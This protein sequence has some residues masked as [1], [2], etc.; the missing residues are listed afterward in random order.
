MWWDLLW[1]FHYTFTSESDGEKNWKSVNILATLWASV[2]CPV[3]YSR[4]IRSLLYT[5]AADCYKL[6]FV[7]FRS[8]G[9]ASPDSR[10]FLIS[11][12]LPRDAMRKCGI[13]CRLVFVGLSVRLSRSYIISRR[14]GIVKLLSRPGNSIIL[15]FFCPQ[16]R[17]PS[18]KGNPL[19]RG[20]KIHGVGK[21]CNFRLKL[22]F[23]SETVRNRPIAT[24]R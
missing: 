1:L 2:G 24:E 18:S 15:A 8:L 6:N 11:F 23:I 12:F 9:G 17:V 21:I 4:G 7:T 16:A 5:T 20:R 3:F 14:L 19:Q 10:H 22:L 13:Y